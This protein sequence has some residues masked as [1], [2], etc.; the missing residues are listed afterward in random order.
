MTR[1]MGKRILLTVDGSDH[2]LK[3]AGYVGRMLNAPDMSLVIF[4]A[5]HKIPDVF[6]DLEANPHI[7]SAQRIAKSWEV[8]QQ[9]KLTA[10]LA[11]VKQIL[12]AEG[13]PEKAISQKIWQVQEGIARDIVAEAG[14]G[15]AAVAMGRKGL[16]L[17]ELLLGGIAS[18][19]LNKLVDVPVILVGGDQPN[20]NVLVAV[21]GSGRREKGRGIRR[22]H[23]PVH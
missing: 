8:S 1:A 21:D 17:L 9:D 19:L 2:S 6:W 14:H 5:L 10:Y 4:H 7:R 16:G 15:Y 23:A 11:K 12:T 22:N 20:K 18:K 13:F 3:T